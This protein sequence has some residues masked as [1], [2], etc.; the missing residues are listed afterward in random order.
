MWAMLFTVVLIV[1]LWFIDHADFVAGI[2]LRDG[3]RLPKWNAWPWRIVHS[4]AP[5]FFLIFW[6]FDFDTTGAYSDTVTFILHGCMATALLLAVGLNYFLAKA[7]DLAE[8]SP[9]DQATNSKITSQMGGFKSG[10][11]PLL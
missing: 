7:V 11:S 6:F 5:L 4:I 2:I 9:A 1:G 10:K 8:Y 3:E